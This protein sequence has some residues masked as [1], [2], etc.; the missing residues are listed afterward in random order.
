MAL[1]L[2]GGGG[3]ALVG[4]ANLRTLDVDDV[5][6]NKKYVGF[7]GKFSY[8]DNG[9]GPSVMGAIATRYT[10][11]NN[12][13]LGALYA[14]S[15][16]DIS[17]EYRIGGG[18]FND[19]PANPNLI[20]SLNTTRLRQTPS[21]HLFKF[22]L[23]PYANHL[24]K[25][26][27]RRYDTHLAGREISANNYQ[28][29]YRFN[30]ES[31]LI[32]SKILI[33]YNQTMQDYDD[34]FT[35]ITLPLNRYF[36]DIKAN[37]QY[38]TIDANNASEFSFFK[39]LHLNLVYGA[40][41]SLN[42]YDR[43]FFW[44]VD[45]GTGQW[46]IN[47]ERAVS[48]LPSGEQQ[49]TTAYLDSN[50][51]Y[52]FMNLS[53]NLNMMYW[54]L[55]GQVG[56]CS[57]REYCGKYYDTTYTYKNFAKD[58]L[59]FNAFVL[60]SM[61]IFKFFQPFISY[62][63]TNRALN[64]QEQFVSGAGGQQVN[65]WLRPESANTYQVGLNIFLDSIFFKEDF[66][67]IKLV[68]FYTDIKDYI[69]DD[70]D[71]N[72]TF[73]PRL[74]GNANYQGIELES[75]FTMPHFYAKLGY[76]YQN[77]E[78]PYSLSTTLAPGMGYGQSQFSRLPKHILNLDM[79]ATLLDSKIILG[80][81]IRYTGG[82]ERINPLSENLEE[83]ISVEKIPDYTTWDMY[84]TF[85]LAKFLTLKLDIQNLLDIDYM[86]ALNTFN[87]SSGNYDPNGITAFNNSA[88]GRTFIGSITARF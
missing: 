31:N 71:T 56:R 50:I 78:F 32:D 36:S 13:R 49:I 1:I 8:G 26:Q 57:N 35:W 80:S 72:Y 84:I 54:N 45:P 61:D 77:S 48:F 30:P 21:S 43:K 76:T 11:K 25:F 47:L 70:W 29:S 52:K 24:I 67:G 9:I 39:D 68:Y 34:D 22:E 85:N 44:K 5:M 63:K 16:K 40:N 2:T 55:M 64:P 82:A 6:R 14:Y 23:E 19:D 20:P 51:K 46:N 18:R 79:G 74:N 62:A 28:I 75:N 15:I 37:N 58:D 53:V 65:V 7:L 27:Y 66:L 88:R 17:Q 86:D 60:Y 42:K 73:V 83:G 81:I 69:Y 12:I 87:S 10:F 33:A 38:V 59:V 4:S 3:N 41:F